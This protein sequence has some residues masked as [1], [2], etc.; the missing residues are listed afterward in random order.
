M[1][2]A[3][4]GMFCDLLSGKAEA[5]YLYRDDHLALFMDIQ[6]VNPGHTLVIAVHH[7][8]GLADLPAEI[9]SRM[10]VVAQII[11]A[12][13][14]KSGL[15]C[16]GVNLFFAD[17]GAAMQEI[18]HTHLHVIPRFSGDGFGLRFSETYNHR[19]SREMLEAAAAKIRASIEE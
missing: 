14:R 10:F 2:N 15:Q 12:A 9:A 1:E 16:D 19:P 6:P 4:S 13:L 8:A 5:T 3:T 11:S 18:F 7:F 17:G